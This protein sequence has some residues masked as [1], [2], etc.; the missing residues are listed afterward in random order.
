MQ[1]SYEKHLDMKKLLVNFSWNWH[2]DSV[3]TRDLS[4]DVGQQRDVHRAKPALLSRRVDPGQVCEVGVGWTSNDLGLILPTYLHE[5]VTHVTPKSVWI[6]SSCQYLFT[7]LGSTGAKAARRML[8]KLTLGQYVFVD[9]RALLL[10]VQ[11]KTCYV[12]IHCYLGLIVK[13][14]LL[15]TFLVLPWT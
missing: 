7:L 13:H 3:V 8:M 15:N 12:G 10:C 14:P 6:Q 4:G 1:K 5:A 11:K 2:Q 9:N